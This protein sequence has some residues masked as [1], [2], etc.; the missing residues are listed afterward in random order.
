[1]IIGQGPE[2]VHY[3]SKAII[4]PCTRVCACVCVCVHCVCVCVHL[5]V[6]VCLCVCVMLCL[7]SKP[8]SLHVNLEQGALDLYHDVARVGG[9]VVDPGHVREAVHGHQL[10]CLVVQQHQLAVVDAQQLGM[11]TTSEFASAWNLGT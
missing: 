1:M 5:C 11:V 7:S 4:V 9:G 10:P 2:S 8:L 6:C 3:A